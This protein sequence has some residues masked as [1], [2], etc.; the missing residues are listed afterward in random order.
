MQTTCLG[1]I[2]GALISACSS[3]TPDPGATAPAATSAPEAPATLEEQSEPVEG[4]AS[5]EGEGAGEV[6]AETEVAEVA[7]V[8]ASTAPILVEGDGDIDGERGDEHLVLR[9]DGT[10][11]A[12]ERRGRAEVWEFGDYWRRQ[13]SLSTV[14][15]DRRGPTRA[16]LLA[17]PIA[18]DEDPP[19]RYQVFLPD[20]ES[21]LRRVLDITVGSYGVQPLIFSGDGTVSYD[22]DGWA[23]CERLGQPAR[24]P[25]QRVTL[26]LEGSHL[27]E[28]SRRNT[29]RVQ[30]CDHLAACPFVY[31][32]DESGGAERVGE[33]L[34]N[35]RGSR[36][37]AAQ[38]LV[39]GSPVAGPLR[40]RLS[41]EKPEVTYVDELYLMVDDIRIPPRS[42]T[43]ASPRP[44]YCLADGEPFVLREGET[45]D[46]AFDA[47]APDA[48]LHATGYY[49]PVR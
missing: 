42:C 36:A 23:A 30:N 43:G 7:T 4:P 3:S 48:T 13:A 5:A 2:L 12:G 32:V 34:R 15:F 11:E 17:L 49:V 14:V 35:L 1:A 45:L 25:R 41:E 38:D 22:E 18:E 29:G 24:A 27:M 37:Y 47:N 19:N 10:L 28:H 33:I 21:G 40:I 26:T 20:G 16:V 8:P 9:E 6:E 46:L 31:R 44:A 39:V